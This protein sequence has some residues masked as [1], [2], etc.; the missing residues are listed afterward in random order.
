MPYDAGRVH[1]ARR[2]PRYSGRVPL[3]TM[4]DRYIGVWLMDSHE[5]DVLAVPDLQA[6]VRCISVRGLSWNKLLLV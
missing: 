3:F 2:I 4:R 1:H 6:R 5:V